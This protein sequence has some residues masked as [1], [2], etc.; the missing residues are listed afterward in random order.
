MT[1]A[2]MTA[3][4]DLYRYYRWRDHVHVQYNCTA[5]YSYS[6]ARHARG[7][8]GYQIGLYTVVVLARSSTVPVVLYRYMYCT[9]TSTGIRARPFVITRGLKRRYNIL[10]RLQ[11]RN[12]QSN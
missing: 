6:S 10:A 7:G 2:T 1:S 5:V 9:S 11:Q 4:S 8:R 12:W 3:T